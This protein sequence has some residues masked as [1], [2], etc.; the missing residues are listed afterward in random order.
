M[1]E[2]KNFT[3]YYG[4][5]K[6]VDDLSFELNQ[7]EFVTLLGPSGCGK[8]TTLHAIAGLVEPSEGS[9]H[10]RGKDITNTPPSERNIGMAF[11]HSALFPHMTA[12][13]NIE[14]GLKMHGYNAADAKQRVQ[15]LLGLVQ[16]PDHGDHRPGE[17]S[18]GQKQRISLARAVAYEPDLLLLDE[19]LTGLD[20]VLR[21]EMRREIKRIQEEVNVTTLYVT[22]DQEE[23][24]SLSDRVVVL[25]DG[26]KQQVGR[27]REIYETPVNPFVAEFVG[28][29]TKFEGTV[30]SNSPLVVRNGNR[31]FYL[32]GNESLA[33]GK[34]VVLYVRPE[35][36][37]IARS[38]TNQKNEFRGHVGEITEL[39]R[40][41]EVL[42]EL[43][44]GTNVL[45]E[46]ERFPPIREGDDVYVSFDPS[47]VITL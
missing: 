25:K 22:H 16:M 38:A 2:V 44:E 1:L 45:V 4:D 6:A 8:S 41:A 18:G 36:I 30:A 15:E 31:E 19:P 43:P 39:G 29:S 28:K 13:E 46:T 37:E 10:L 27:P 14:Y 21:E 47:N 34:Q 11:Q 7:G 23:A 3:K 24:L 35:D 9:I 33:D 17:L 42:V 32:N 20:R 12:E 26:R 5:L 40:F